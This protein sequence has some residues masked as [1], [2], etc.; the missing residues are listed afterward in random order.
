M[1]QYGSFEC[2]FGPVA[3]SAAAAMA[4][5]GVVSYAMPTLNNGFSGRFMAYDT[6]DIKSVYV[7]FSSVS[8]P[9]TVELRIE[10]IDNTTGKPSGTLYDANATKS[11]TPAA[12]WNTVTFDT[13]PT[14]GLV[15]T[16]NFEIEVNDLLSIY[17]IGK[18]K[19][20]FSSEIL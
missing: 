1:P 17:T 4:A 10:T 18:G 14:T 16:Y 2:F 15:G 3:N 7:N 19:I 8:A 13:L 20:I 11:F 9:G 6:R 12:G 5:S